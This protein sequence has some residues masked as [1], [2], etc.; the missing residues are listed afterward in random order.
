VQSHARGWA[1]T[2]KHNC[3]EGACTLWSV[4][5]IVASH[6]GSA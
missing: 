2:A 4:R 5:G 1:L 6:G 3:S